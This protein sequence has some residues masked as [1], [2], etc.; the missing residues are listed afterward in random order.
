M[1][2]VAN[3]IEAVKKMRSL[4]KAY[5]SEKEKEKRQALLIQ[6]K[7]AEKAVDFIIIKLQTEGFE[8]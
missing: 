3:F 6:S 4:Q 1:K 8:L 7:Q 2:E 5:F